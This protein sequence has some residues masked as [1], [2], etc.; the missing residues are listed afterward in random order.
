MKITVEG[1]TGEGKSSMGVLLARHLRSL[2][3]DVTHSDPEGPE[4]AIGGSVD[5]LIR[6]GGKVE[7]EAKATP[8]SDTSPPY[9]PKWEYQTLHPAIGSDYVTDEDLNRLGRR[10]WEAVTINGPFR[11]S[12]AFMK[13]RLN[14]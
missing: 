8:L 12:V 6:V 11:A 4:E 1:V 3:F 9:N 7:V 2:G 10:G 14:G 13:R 5:A